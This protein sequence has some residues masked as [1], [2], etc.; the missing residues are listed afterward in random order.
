LCD[1][2]ENEKAVSKLK[3]VQ[4]ETKQKLQEM[5]EEKAHLAS[6]LANRHIQSYGAD[7]AS[8]H[9]KLQ[10][11]L[12]R[13]TALRLDLDK[14]SQPLTSITSTHFCIIRACDPSCV[15]LDER[16]VLRTGDASEAR[17]VQPDER[18]GGETE[19]VA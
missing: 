15:W 7:S 9:E 8:L 5:A 10:G 11:A 12:S 19:R 6:Q 16:L 2:V 3:E 1:K 14:V 17:R 18:F 4:L 13:E